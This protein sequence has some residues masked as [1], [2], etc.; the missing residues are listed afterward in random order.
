MLLDDDNGER[1]RFLFATFFNL[2]DALTLG[3]HVAPS[4]ALVAAQPFSSR[5]Q[6]LWFLPLTFRANIFLQLAPVSAKAPLLS[7]VW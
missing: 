6:V 4:H 3:L 1:H 7:A 5:R 2:Y